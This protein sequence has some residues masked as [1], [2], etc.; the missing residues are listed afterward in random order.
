MGYRSVKEIFNAVFDSPNPELKAVSKTTDNVLNLIYDPEAN[1]LRVNLEG[2]SGNII[3]G[4]A[5]TFTDLPT[6]AEHTGDIYIV[7]TT[8]GVLL[9][10]RKQAGLYRSDGANWNLLDVD[11]QADKVYYTGSL[12]SGNVQD[13]LNE[14][15]GITDGKL[16]TEEQ[17]AD[18]AKLESKTLAEILAGL[19]QQ[20]TIGVAEIST[21]G[22]GLKLPNT[23]STDP[24][25]LDWY[26][27]GVWLPSLGTLYTASGVTGSFVSLSYAGYTRIGNLVTAGLVIDF[28]EAKALSIDDRFIVSGLPY[29]AN[30][31]NSGLGTGLMYGSI[32]AGN[33]AQWSISA[34][35][36]SLILQCIHIDGTLDYTNS[37]RLNITYRI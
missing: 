19:I 14:L 28:S 6:A 30:V 16:G 24:D 32:G 23:A 15:K 11:L 21:P 31:P 8:T 10:N 12:I 2:F 26:E 1:A 22:G 4:E 3:D 34:N 13:A 20:D 25:V 18:S 5:D 7:R 35:V 17:A 36:T 37:I 9:I 27:E 29:A 33:N